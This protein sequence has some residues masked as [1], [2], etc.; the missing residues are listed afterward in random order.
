[1]GPLTTTILGVVFLLLG[2]AA[3]VT[4]LWRQGRETGERGMRRLRFA[5]RI[6]GYG[7]ALIFAVLFVTMLKRIVAFWEE[8]SPRINLHEAL[9][10]GLLFL[11]SAK[12][13]IPRV[14]PRLNRH[15]FGLGIAIYFVSF[16][17][18]G[19]TGGYY[20]A[21]KIQRTPYI[22]HGDT[23]SDVLDEA[24]GKELLIRK[25]SPCHQM[26]SILQPRS[27]EAWEKVVNDMVELASPRINTAEGEQILF[28]LT[29]N[30]EPRPAPPAVPSSSAIACPAT[31]WTRSS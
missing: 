17:L 14:F 24:L 10:V 29:E 23:S 11:L 31:R 22:V 8:S 15:L 26:Q 12:L 13:A 2:A 20:V 18:V 19:V 6:A 25:C 1:M 5:H 7:F 21:R 27:H 4:M 9:A 16:I 28:Y 3:V 30:L